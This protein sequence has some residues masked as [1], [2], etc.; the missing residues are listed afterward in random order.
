MRALWTTAGLACVG[1]GAVGVVLPLLP[2]VPF[3]LLAAFCFARGSDRFH[4][5][6]MNHPRFGPPIKDWRAHGAISRKGKVA[7]TVAI[8]AAL[9]ISLILGVATKFLLIQCA[10]LSCVLLFIHTRPHGPGSK[11]ATPGTSPGTRPG[12]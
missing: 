5:W 11:A 4:D 3:M 2:T 7:A 12:R 6:L 10:V 9:G 8:L 1:I